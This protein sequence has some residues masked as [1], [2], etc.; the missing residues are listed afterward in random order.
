MY[1]HWKK[2]YKEN[3]TY[4]LLRKREDPE[5]RSFPSAMIAIL[6][7]SKSASSLTEKFPE[8]LHL[9]NSGMQ[10]KITHMECVESKIVLPSLCLTSRS[11]MALLAYGSI[12]DV[13]SSSITSFDPPIKAIPALEIRKLLKPHPMHVCTYCNPE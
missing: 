4:L 2:R 7:P 10:F 11:Q 12:P 8:I 9:L 13:G 6:S 1:L 3:N 5:Q